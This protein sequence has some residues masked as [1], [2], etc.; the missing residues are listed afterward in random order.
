M[1]V[2]ELHDCYEARLR[3]A[4]LHSPVG[5]GVARLSQLSLPPTLQLSCSVL[6]NDLRRIVKHSITMAYSLECLTTNRQTFG[7]TWGSDVRLPLALAQLV[8]LVAYA[9]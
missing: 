6:S 2:G 7:L 1:Q 8:A 9:T 3:P 4:H 5:T